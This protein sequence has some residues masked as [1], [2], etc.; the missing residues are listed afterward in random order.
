MSA[1]FLPR[2]VSLTP[3]NLATYQPGPMVEA[4]RTQAL[5][6]GQTD[7]LPE[8][9]Q[10]TVYK[11]RGAIKG[12]NYAVDRDTTKIPRELINDALAL[13]VSIAKTRLTLDLNNAEMKAWSDAEDHLTEIRLSKF[14]VSI[15]DDPVPAAAST[16]SS[17]GASLVRPGN[18]PKREDFNGL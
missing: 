5:L 3:E 4:F 11:I 16:Q 1:E 8:A 18:V 14:P 7:P 17:G 2:W 13:I 10:N 6:K 9:I 12:G 15:P